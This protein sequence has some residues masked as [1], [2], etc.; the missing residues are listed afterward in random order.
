MV[1][2]EKF[3]ASVNSGQ[4]EYT[5]LNFL[6]AASS[7]G[8][9]YSKVLVLAPNHEEGK[10]GLGDGQFG[11]GM[12]P[13]TSVAPQRKNAAIEAMSRVSKA[14]EAVNNKIGVGKTFTKIQIIY[15]A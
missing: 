7:A 10:A 12:L 6:I 3:E 2:F 1:P 4:L 11:C 13:W 14:Q 15:D 8:S 5:C 9:S